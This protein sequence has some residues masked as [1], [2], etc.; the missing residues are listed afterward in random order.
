MVATALHT[1][2][3]TI[4]AIDVSSRQLRSKEELPY[5][6]EQPTSFSLPA[7]AVGRLRAAAGR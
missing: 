1:P 4:H 2:D 6:N 7:E 3:T 5:L